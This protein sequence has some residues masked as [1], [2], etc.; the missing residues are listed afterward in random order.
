MTARTRFDAWRADQ[1]IQCPHGYAT[2]PDIYANGDTVIVFFDAE[3]VAR[4]GPIR[5]S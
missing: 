5:G 3:G 4:D 2:S 1:A